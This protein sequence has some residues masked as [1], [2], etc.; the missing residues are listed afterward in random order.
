M[1]LMKCGS[2][3][4]RMRDSMSR[5]WEVQALFGVTLPHLKIPKHPNGDSSSW[6]S[7]TNAEWVKCSRIWDIVPNPFWKKPLKIC[8]AKKTYGSDSADTI[9]TVPVK[10]QWETSISLLIV[11]AT[12]IGTTPS[13]S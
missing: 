10:Q 4:F 13:P 2:S 6:V 3:T 5:S 12:M 8:G 1:K 9:K 7:P 11:T